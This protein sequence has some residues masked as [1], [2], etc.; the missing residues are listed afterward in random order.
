MSMEQSTADAIDGLAAALLSADPA[1]KDDLVRIGASLEKVLTAKGAIPARTL[2]GLALVLKSLIAVYEG[3]VG[4]ASAAMD[5]SAAALAAAATDL[6]EP[7]EDGHSFAQAISSLRSILGGRAESPAPPAAVTSAPV[8]PL[9][10][11]PVE[12]L[13]AASSAPAAPATTN[14]HPSES[15][16]P[17]PAM[18]PAATAV[19]ADSTAGESADKLP[20]DTD[21][22]LLSE[23][24]NECLDHIA[25]AEAA[26]LDLEHNPSAP[27]PVNVIFRAFHTIKGTSGFLGLE[28]IQRVAHLAENLLDRA[29][30]GAIR[31]V[32]GYADLALHSCDI[33]RKMIQGL[34]G[35]LPGGAL[36][37]PA[38]YDDLVEQLGNP[39]GC[40]VGEQ[41]ESNPLRLG[42]ILVARQKAP[43]E[44][45]EKGFENQ[46]GR[47]IGRALIEEGVVGAT[48]VA[49]ALRTQTQQRGTSSDA[50]VRVGTDRLDS[51]IDAVGELV[52]AQSMVAQDPLILSGRQP[53]LARNVSHAGK[54]VRELQDVSMSLR[55]VPLKATFGKM[56]RLVRDLARKAGKQVHFV[57]EGED[58]EIDRNMVEVLGD[59][60]VHM[61]RNAVD[62]GIEAP[63]VRLAAGKD[64]AGTIRLRAYH[65]AGNVVLEIVDDGKGL[66]CAKIQAKA[67]ER[68][69]IQP[70]D[71]LSEA[72]AFN[73]IFRPGF[74][75]AEKVTD[76]SGRGVGMDVVKTGIESLRGRVEIASRPG[77]GSTFTIRLPL[78]MAIADAMLLRV[79]AQR[80]LLPVV[81][82][83]RSFRPESG[84]IS[85]VIGRG[86]VVHMRGELLPVFRLHRLFGVETPAGGDRDA[87]LIIIQG[88]GK[89]CALM[90]DELLGQQQVVVKSLGRSF[91]KVRGVAGGAIL[92]DG[93]VGL[94]L[95]A[96]GLVAL[97]GGNRADISRAAA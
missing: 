38:N 11:V 89:R 81:A 73:L 2:D 94:I 84:A 95:D 86:E 78:T 47:P 30:D 37:I 60:L 8:Q 71:T 9:S 72:E 17:P 90:V 64:A 53:Q 14:N 31:V 33:L 54:I 96:A 91:E 68:G 48:D 46:G 24:I 23:F 69:L 61:M 44:A 3:K 66:D 55:M 85:T 42:D 87:L 43:R 27:E 16:A 26:L 63:G 21:A 74:S 57:P 49:Q 77:A 65:A 25:G 35:V 62:H 70:G 39:E 51:L 75:T 18:A 34:S 80:Y 6:R 76:V 41:V 19:A 50:T 82:I 40:G 15:P 4:D 20:A 58:T 83:E 45:I 92:G 12:A 97:A 7:G 10:P 59:P 28:R 36:P 79:G 93:R 67:V 29:R 1:N 5:T 32:G 22:S 56:A 52:I 13:K 88:Q